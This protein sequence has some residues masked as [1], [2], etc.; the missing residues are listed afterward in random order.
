MLFQFLLYS[1][2]N[3]L[4]VYIYALFLKFPSHSGLQSAEISLCYTIDSQQLSLKIALTG[5]VL[6]RGCGGKL[7]AQQVYFCCFVKK[8]TN[9]PKNPYYRILRFCVCV[10]SALVY[11]IHIPPLYGYVLLTIY[12]SALYG[13][14]VCSPN[15]GPSIQRLLLNHERHWDSWPPENS[16]WGW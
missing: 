11:I 9:K 5:Q 2:I 7:R 1:K 8:K 3:Q 16:I 12:N 10:C 15:S 6:N 4:Y 14:V 13:N